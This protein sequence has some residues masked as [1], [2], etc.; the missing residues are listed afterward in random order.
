MY[1]N[2]KSNCSNNRINAGASQDDF[3]M[4]RKTFSTLNPKVCKKPEFYDLAVALSHVTL[5]K[6]V[7]SPR[8]KKRM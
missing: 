3:L 6:N 5:S 7:F 1:L 4:Q 8:V 2:D